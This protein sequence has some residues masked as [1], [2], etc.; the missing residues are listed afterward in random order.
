M[1]RVMDSQ[2]IT[3]DVKNEVTKGLDKLTML[4]DEAKLHLHLATLDAK[5]E[6]DKLEPRIDEL[7]AKAAEL[8]ETSKT[9]VHELVDRV[10]SFV[11]KLKNRASSHS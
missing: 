7:Q 1:R 6:W 10:E 5:Q 9:A 2:K 11:T 4:R 8:T 3:N